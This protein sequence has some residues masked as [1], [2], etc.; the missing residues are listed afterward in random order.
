MDV[1]LEESF[2]VKRVPWFGW[3][4]DLDC[5]LTSDDDDVKPWCPKLPRLEENERCWYTQSLL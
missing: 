4:E 3:Y 2:E 5:L 1:A